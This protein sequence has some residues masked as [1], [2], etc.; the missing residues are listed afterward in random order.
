MPRHL[1]YAQIADDLVDRIARGEYPPGTRLPSYTQLAELYDVSSTAS[2]GAASFR[3]TRQSPWGQARSA[4][5]RAGPGVAQS[6]AS[7]NW[8]LRR[9][10]YAL[11]R[12]GTMRT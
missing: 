4:R 7:D 11:H 12:V 10:Y 6:V 1:T 2:Q 9:N 5:L 8:L 3:K